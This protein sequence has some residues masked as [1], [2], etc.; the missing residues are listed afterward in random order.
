MEPLMARTKDIKSLFEPLFG[1]LETELAANS[2]T[3]SL[4][5]KLKAQYL[6]SIC[7]SAQSI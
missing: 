4:R 5:L 2:I 3:T 6:D 1:K 7:C